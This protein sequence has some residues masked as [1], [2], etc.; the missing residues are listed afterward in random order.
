M[1]ALLV[2]VV[3]VGASGAAVA[4]APGMS[5]VWTGQMRQ[6]EVDNEATYPMRLTFAGKSAVADY[7]T[8]NCSGIWSKVTEK[9][10]YAIYAEEAANRDGAT[11]IDGMVMVKIDKGKVFVGWFA[12]YDGAPTVSTAVLSKAAE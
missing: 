6:I 12:A 2:A 1:R 9:N 11:C 5:G 3:A 10:G 4:G 7:P 8:L